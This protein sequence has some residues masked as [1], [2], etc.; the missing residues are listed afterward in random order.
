MN[1]GYTEILTSISS[2]NPTPGGG[3]VAAL[4]LAHAHS[5]A[6]MVSRLTIRSEKW[7]DGH[8]TARRIIVESQIGVSRSLELANLDAQA[9]DAVMSAYRMPKQSDDE[10][11]LRKKAIIDATIQAAEVPLHTAQEACSMLH[12]IGDLS[13]NCNVNA[14]TDLASSAEL[15]NTSVTLAS[16]N[17]RINI[18]S[19][20]NEVSSE[21][22]S[23]IEEATS[24]ANSRLSDI[25]GVISERL[26]W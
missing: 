23:K 11:S 3:S 19:L 18:V 25:M 4:I 14:L 7:A 9:F 24:I 26:G 8:D 21:L 1:D 13:R 20:D 17:V 5:L 2:S 12:S 16:L 22:S 6:I 10:I 15:A